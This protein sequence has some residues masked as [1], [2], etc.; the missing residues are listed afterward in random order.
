MIMKHANT[1]K[2]GAIV[3]LNADEL[4]AVSGGNLD[5]ARGDDNISVWYDPRTGDM[6]DDT[7]PADLPP[8]PPVIISY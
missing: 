5:G 7:T 1:P 6:G 3:E 8:L 2:T 4:N